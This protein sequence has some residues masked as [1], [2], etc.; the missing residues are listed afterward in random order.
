MRLTAVF[1]LGSIA[2]A[3][4]SSTRGHFASKWLSIEVG[5]TTCNVLNYGAKGDGKTDDTKAVQS[6]I[7][8]CSSSSGGIALL[9]SGYTFVVSFGFLLCC[10]TR[11][12]YYQTP[13]SVIPV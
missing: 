9:P 11:P 2:A 3:T 10:H 12:K 7:P 1:F 4:A 5:S 6:A 8:A 13:L